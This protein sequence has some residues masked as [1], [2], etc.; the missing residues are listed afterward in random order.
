MGFKDALAA[1]VDPHLAATRM[2]EAQKMVAEAWTE[3][4]PMGAERAGPT[5]GEP[6]TLVT[7]FSSHTSRL[8]Q[9]PAAVRAE[10]YAPLGVRL[11]FNPASAAVEA[12]GGRSHE[13]LGRISV[14][15]A[16]RYIRTRL[17]SA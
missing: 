5:R 16:T 4:A 7:G 15:G 6:R 10:I 2:D 17:G 12:E 11:T 3:Q 8:G 1:G 13:M 9:V 14:R